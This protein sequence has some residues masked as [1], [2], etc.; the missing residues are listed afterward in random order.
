MSTVSKPANEEERLS[1]L[2]R[3]EILD[4]APDQA[5]DDLALLAAEICGTP[6]ATITLI[7]ADRQ[8]FKARIG[9][10]ASE[11]P[12]DDAFCALTVLHPD[13]VF[14]VP[15]TLADARFAQNPAV[16]A[17]PHFRFYAGAPLVVA[18]GYAVGTVAVLDTTPRSL[19]PEKR[20]ALQALA[21]RVRDQRGSAAIQRARQRHV[22]DPAGWPAKPSL[23]TAR[24]VF[25]Q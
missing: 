15:D 4:T 2:R 1:A 3:Y 12:R 18:G 13:R 22:R 21:R 10:G 5:F 20:L 19:T 11:T 7:D 24:A 17:A 8:W 9:M 23:R 16:L 6:T 14:E 25:L